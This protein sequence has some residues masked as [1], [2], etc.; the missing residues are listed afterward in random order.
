VVNNADR[1]AGHC[2]KAGVGR[3]LAIDH[4]ICFN[5][6]PKLRTVVWDFAGQ[7]IPPDLAAD[8]RRFQASLNASRSPLVGELAG[9]LSAAE[10]VALK[11]RLAAL[12]AAGRFPEPPGDR[13][14]IPWPPV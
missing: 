5:V 8:L 6:E 12:L 3:I 4:G 13:P 14:A 1:K 11:A 9:L 10:I 2:L 7:P